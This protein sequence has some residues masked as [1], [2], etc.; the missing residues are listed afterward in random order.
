[1]PFVV[2]EDYNAIFQGKSKYCNFYGKKLE[3]QIPSVD[4]V[5]VSFNSLFF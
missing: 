5:Y 3:N 4:E 1:M 2:C